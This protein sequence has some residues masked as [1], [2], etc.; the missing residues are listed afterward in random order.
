MEGFDATEREG[1][2]LFAIGT[3]V[4][5]F[6][7]SSDLFLEFGSLDPRDD[8]AQLDFANRN[9]ALTAGVY[10]APVRPGKPSESAIGE[11]QEI[12]HSTS[13]G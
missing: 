3:A 5:I 1:T 11:F 13:H 7:P 2:A 4:R 6:R 8:S 12:W 10:L 9:G